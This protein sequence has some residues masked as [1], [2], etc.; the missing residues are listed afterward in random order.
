MGKEVNDCFSEEGM[1]SVK[2]IDSETKIPSLMDEAQRKVKLT[3]CLSN[4]FTSSTKEHQEVLSFLE[5]FNN[6]F[7]LSEGERGETNLVE[8]TIETGDAVSKK[9]AVRRTPFAVR[10]EIA[11]Q[12]QRMLEQRVI[13]PSSSPWGS[14]IVLV[15]KKDSSLRFCV[16]YSSFNSVQFSSSED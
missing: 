6:V 12:L 15:R 1:N 7:S 8:M 9:Q 5:N 4:G 16:D 10:H 14:P 11:V 2:T 3:E 13:Q